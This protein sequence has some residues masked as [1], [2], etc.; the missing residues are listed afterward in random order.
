MYLI[1]LTTQRKKRERI[2]Y[3]FVM[4]QILVTNGKV[5]CTHKKAER[6]PANKTTFRPLSAFEVFKNTDTQ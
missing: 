6:S 3:V 4:K 2:N 1:G 5:C